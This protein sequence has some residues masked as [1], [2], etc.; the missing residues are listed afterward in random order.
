MTYCLPVKEGD[1]VAQGQV[2][3]EL[4]NQDIQAQ[5][6]LAQSET[7]AANANANQVCVR[8]AVASRESERQKKLQKKNLSSEEA[9]DRA[10]GEARAQKE[11]F[12][13]RLGA[14][15]KLLFFPEGTSTDGNR[16]GPFKSALFSAVFKEAGS[17]VSV[18]TLALR[19]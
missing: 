19:P 1:T 3:M 15:H 4:W 12:E 7:K 8:A 2:L 17:D 16:V 9:V 6:E 10:D 5:Y 18:Q 11:L 13:A 14:G